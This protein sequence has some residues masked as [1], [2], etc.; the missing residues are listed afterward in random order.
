MRLCQR[1]NARA[2]G[3]LPARSRPGP[4]SGR[5][6]GSSGGSFGTGLPGIREWA[7]YRFTWTGPISGFEPGELQDRSTLR[8]RLGYAPDKRVCVVTAGG[9]AVG[10]G[11]IER[12]LEAVPAL[13][14]RVP[15][16]RMVVAAGPR[17]DTAGLR[18][19]DHVDVH[20][21]LPNLH[22][23]LAAADV[24][25]VAGG[26]TTALELMMA[27]RPFVWVPLRRHAI[28][29][30]HVAHR[31]QRRGGP[32]PTEYGQLSAEALA[33]AVATQLSTEVRYHPIQDG[34]LDHA[35]DRLAE[36]L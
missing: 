31:I 15:G 20:G 13:E 1:G 33:S 18:A 10:R 36:L 30:Q 4:V 16:L 12:C 19:P 24:A 5:A 29:R 21:Y 6:R 22:L 3:A 26:G 35:A 17:I 32:S 7:R 8:Q 11:L 2:G 14:A 25:V 28:Q 9:T 23:H 27:G 34:G